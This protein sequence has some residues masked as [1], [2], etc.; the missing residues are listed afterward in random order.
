M[1]VLRKLVLQDFGPFK[2]TQVLDFPA[3]GVALVHG[4]N[5]RGKTSLLNAI[6]YAFFGKLPSE[7]DGSARLRTEN[8]EAV[9][10]GRR[11]FKVVLAFEHRGKEYELTREVR[12]ARDVLIPKADADFESSVF[13][14]RGGRVFKTGEDTEREIARIMPE[15]VSRFF[16]FDGELLQQY[17]EL[18]HD[19]SETGRAI[20]ES[21]ERI[22][23]VP[24]LT[25]ALVDVTDGFRAAEKAEAAALQKND[26]TKELGKQLSE[27]L[28]Q[29]SH[30][31]E[32]IRRRRHE[33]EELGVKRTSLEDR[34]G[35]VAR[36]SA[37]LEEKA[38]AEDKVKLIEERLE[39]RSAELREAMSTTWLS[40]LQPQLTAIRRQLDAELHSISE[41]RYAVLAQDFREKAA[42]GGKCTIC[43]SKIDKVK[44]EAMAVAGSSSP[45]EVER[46]HSRLENRRMRLDALQSGSSLDKVALL[47]D[48][49]AEEKV[50]VADLRRRISELDDA[51][52]SVPIAEVEKVQAEY[53][54][55]ND[56]IAYAKKGL[57]DDVAAETSLASKIKSIEDK[58]NKDIGPDVAAEKRRRDVY[59]KL[60][61][62]FEAGIGTYREA[63]RKDV[64]ARASEIFVALRHEKEYK[65]LKIND[66]YGLSIIHKDG[67]IVPVRSAGQEQIVALALMGALQ[68]NAPL[69]GPL[70]MDT[71]LAR[72]DPTHR[73]NVIR[74]LPK[75]T[76]QAVL[77]VHDG[78]IKPQV[79][80]D[81]LKGR[82][83][84]VRKLAR[85]SARHTVLE[86]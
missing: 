3:V 35:K 14:K 61:N 25:N 16:L 58:R 72:L 32:E 8:A 44:L 62:L 42:K 13:L 70:I 38:K 77:L 19:E 69:K 48:S 28:V 23:G 36:I 49:I 41:M 4:D 37:Q 43:G 20:K 2:G 66:N 50:D 81:E 47:L 51:M 6:K 79:V 82:L 12:V 7:D 86:A 24:V 9:D 78:E 31:Q 10:E 5:G 21:I 22:L 75:L 15:K 64:E 55:V 57:T 46:E 74:T 67:R 54:K 83:K 18:L 29:R 52:R 40:V 59:E 80:R 53:S 71:S 85:K 26:K 17:T 65:A 1:L 56:D 63:L 45:L 30:L 73:L 33:L 27:L 60:K 68:Q 39:G 76:D 11:G 84:L 34:L